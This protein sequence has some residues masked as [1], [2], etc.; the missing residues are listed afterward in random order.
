[1]GEVNPDLFVDQCYFGRNGYHVWGNFTTSDSAVRLD[2]HNTQ[3]MKFQNSVFYRNEGGL[4]ISAGSTSASARLEG[5]V[6]NCAFANN[7]YAETLRLEGRDYQLIYVL[8]NYFGKNWAPYHDTV[9]VNRILVNFTHN[10]FFNNTGLHIVD[11]TGYRQVATE[12]QTFYNN[13][14]YDNLAMGHGY[15]FGVKYGYFP[16]GDVGYVYREQKRKKRQTGENA[17]VVFLNNPFDRP[18]QED[19]VPSPGQFPVDGTSFEWWA[20]V[21]LET[22]RYRSTILAGTGQQHYEMNFFNNPLN[23]FELTT[24]TSSP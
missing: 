8:N 7:H 21:G 15:Q 24:V 12:F 3:N 2:L 6:K 10:I 20:N 23:D 16:D 22:E 11:L 9:F 5:V 4:R 14:L 17:D 18:P 19:L 1:M 13:F